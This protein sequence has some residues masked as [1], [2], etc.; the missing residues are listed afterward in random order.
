MHV[1]IGRLEIRASTEPVPT[2][3]PTVS[4]RPTLGLD[5]YLRRRGEAA[6]P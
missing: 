3:P 6:R 2:A 1:T 5:D 4:R